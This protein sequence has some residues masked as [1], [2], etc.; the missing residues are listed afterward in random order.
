M[1]RPRGR[2]ACALRSHEAGLAGRVG[3]QGAG[4]GCGSGAGGGHTGPTGRKLSADQE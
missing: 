2:I 1:G 3:G 4:R